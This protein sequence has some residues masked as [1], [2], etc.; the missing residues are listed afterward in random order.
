[1]DLD[2]GIAEMNCRGP[3]TRHGGRRPAKSGI[4]NR[5]KRDRLERVIKRGMEAQHESPPLP[6]PGAGTLPGEADT[7]KGE[8]DRNYAKCW[9]LCMRYN[10]YMLRDKKQDCKI[11]C[12]AKR[13]HCY[14]TARP[15]HLQIRPEF[16][17]MMGVTGTQTFEEWVDSLPS[18]RPNWKYGSYEPG[19]FQARPSASPPASGQA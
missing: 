19:N 9:T 15:A 1:D 16:R 8:C 12:Y 11:R 3:K 18:T 7:K 4:P 17:E 5:L 10:N 2:E 6:R 14:F 13:R